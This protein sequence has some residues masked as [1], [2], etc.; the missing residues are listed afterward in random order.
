MTF[1]D[2]HSS[3]SLSLSNRQ[4]HSLEDAGSAHMKSLEP[5]YLGCEKRGGVPRKLGEWSLVIA[6]GDV[7]GCLENF[8]SSLPRET[9][10]AVVC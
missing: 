1:R 5:L 2:G 6:E 10:S 4:H 9:S 7:R 8:S 3:K